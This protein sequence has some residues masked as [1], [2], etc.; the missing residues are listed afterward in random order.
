MDQEK[1]SSLADIVFR[2]QQDIQ[3]FVTK[4]VTLKSSEIFEKLKDELFTEEGKKQFP[5][6][7]ILGA[8]DERSLVVS[9]F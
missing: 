6:S 2:F 3:P 7:L 4:E 9:E 1:Q 5:F 8:S